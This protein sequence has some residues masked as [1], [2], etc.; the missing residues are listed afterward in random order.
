MECQR[1]DGFD[2][3]WDDFVLTNPSGTFF[4]LLRWRDIVSRSFGHEPFYLYAEENGQI[5]GVLPLFL[6]KSLLFG[7]SLVTVP[8]GVYGGVV[9]ACHAAERFLFQAAVEL[10]R[11]LR[12]RYIEVRGNPF[13]KD[14]VR[15]SVGGEPDGLQRSDLYVTFQREIDSDPEINLSRIPRKQRRMIR[16]GQKHGLRSVMD[17]NRLRDF[18]TVYAESV[19]NLG[20]PVY[21]YRY[22]QQLTKV[23]GD[24]CRVLLVE[25]QE[26]TI[27]GVLTF[28]YKDQML[29]Y[30]GGSLPAYRDLAPN[31]FMYW[32]LLCFGAE[33]G[34]KVFD[35]G[36]SKVDSGSFHFKRHWG[37]EPL[38][39]PYHY[40]CVNGA[41]IPDTSSRNPRLQWAVKLWRHLPLKLTMALGPHLVRH[42]P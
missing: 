3:R 29:P 16:Q 22:F 28:F 4:H 2:T 39:L 18:Y 7:K 26:K 36:R 9:G 27:A 19:R 13:T 33:Q 20:T 14:S 17:E 10:A 37:F 6:V 35:F 15:R 21:S 11:K 34:F 25:H 1:C 12:V 31:D 41:R 5:V 42:I 40:Y 24:A 32:E 23:M 8:L 30:Y 38:A